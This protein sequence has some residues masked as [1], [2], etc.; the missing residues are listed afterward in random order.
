MER[1]S[2]DDLTRFLMT[3]GRDRVTDCSADVVDLRDV[4]AERFDLGAGRRGAVQAAREGTRPVEVL[5]SGRFGL[6]CST[7]R[8]S[9]Y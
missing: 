2:R 5:L 7:R 3:I 8:S 9:A 4:S 6:S 1:D